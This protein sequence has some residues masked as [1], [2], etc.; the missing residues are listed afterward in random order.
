MTHGFK[1][2]RLFAEQGTIERTGAGEFLSF[3]DGT[4]TWKL[5][6]STGNP[7]GIV[8]ADTGSVCSDTTSGTLYT[9]TTD[10]SSVGW[11]AT[12]SGVTTFPTGVL[13]GD[14]TTDVTGSTVTQYGTVVAGASNSVA[15]VAPSA[16]SGVPL[17]S[18]GAAANP[19]YGTAVVAGGG[20]GATTLTGVLTGN[21]TGAFTANAITQYAPV[22]GGASNA[23]A[24]TAVGTAGQVLQSSGAGVAAAYSTATYPAATTVSQIL[25]SSA[26]N[27]VAGLAT[28]NSAALV[29]SS[30]GVPSLAAMTSGQ[31][32]VGNTGG[33][34]TAATPTSIGGTYLSGAGSLK[35]IPANYEQGYSNFGISYSAGTFTV[36]GYDG[37][38]LS[39]TNPGY[40][41]LQSRGTPGRLVTIPVTANQTFTDGSSGT[42]DN[43]RFDVTS[44]V[45]WGNPVPFFLYA[46]S[47]DSENTIAFMICRNPA[48]SKS[49]AS[50]RISKSGAIINGSQNDFFS[51]LDIT[52]T[53]YDNNPCV[54]IGSFR[55]TFAGATDSWTVSTLAVTD[56]I[57]QF[58]DNVSFYFPLGQNGATAG[59]FMFD[60]G[61]TAPTWQIAQCLYRVKKDGSLYVMYGFYGDVGADGAGAQNATWVL[62]LTPAKVSVVD[63]LGVG[64]LVCSALSLRFVGVISSASDY[65]FEL[66]HSGGYVLNSDFGDGHRELSA[67]FTC[68]ISNT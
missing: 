32:I 12:G 46:V 37:A 7:N 62:P 21:G 18:Q 43:A 9:K 54:C 59:K 19:A 63:S 17:I 56:G 15:S 24:S 3:E 26:T 23:V 14:G 25:Y 30:T 39:A 28:A 49:V 34:P 64:S 40:V 38:A 31:L 20:T 5:F 58:N 29:T 2:G 42:I 10:G 57:G 44:G 4:N 45:N 52:V 16:T 51:L 11:V 6:N 35:Y 50:T 27:T 22:I 36:H 60:N 68:V 33:T 8:T 13:T 1:N 65:Y 67:L 61:G 48:F 55:M 53:D 41:T 47:N 66:L